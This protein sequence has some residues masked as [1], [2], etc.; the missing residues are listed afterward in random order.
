MVSAD[1]K[2]VESGFP[3]R[4]F[5]FVGAFKA[6]PVPVYIDSELRHL[7]LDKRLL[8]ICVVGFVDVLSCGL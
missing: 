4:N 7:F 2:F 3:K 5:T 8:I 6:D 1:P